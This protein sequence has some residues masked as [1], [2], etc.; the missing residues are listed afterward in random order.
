M[1][2]EFRKFAESSWNV[3]ARD[4]AAQQRGNVG[5]LVVLDFPGSL[6]HAFV[7]ARALAFGGGDEEI[8]ALNGEGAGV[9]VGG[10]ETEGQPMGRTVP[11]RTAGSP[12][13][14][15]AVALDPPRFP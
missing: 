9:P 15:P 6:A 11:I 10:D 13:Q 7:R 14:S 2:C 12:S 5:M 8:V 4:R 3:Q 1:R